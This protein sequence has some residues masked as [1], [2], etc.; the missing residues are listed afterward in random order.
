TDRRSLTADATG[1][2]TTSYV[3]DTDYRYYAHTAEGESPTALTRLYAIS[4]TGPAQ[5]GYGA[6]VT[7]TGHK[8]PGSQV[9]LYFHHQNTT[10]YA[11]RRPVTADE[12]GPFTTTVTPG[13]D[14]R[15]YAIANGVRSN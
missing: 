6:P 3:A 7:I 2:F 10:G 14:P 8:A 4:L 5:A 9:K 15:Y 13:A 1:A 11:L 12:Q